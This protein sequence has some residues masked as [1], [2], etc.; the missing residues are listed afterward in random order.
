VRLRGNVRSCNDDRWLVYRGKWLYLGTQAQLAAMKFD[1]DDGPAVI[2]GL[3]TETA[4]P[5]NASFVTTEEMKRG[6]RVSIDV[7]SWQTTDALLSPELGPPD[8]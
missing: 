6:K 2:T 5:R 4:I 7:K 3:V 1:L 8:E